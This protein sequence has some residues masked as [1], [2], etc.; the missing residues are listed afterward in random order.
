MV[1]KTNRRTFVKASS[2]VGSSILG[3]SLSDLTK[4]KRPERL[5]GIVYHNQTLEKIG[6]V[7][8]RL[9][10]TNDSVEGSIRLPE[11]QFNVD[12]MSPL[13]VDQTRE[14]RH[15]KQKWP[16]AHDKFSTSLTLLDTDREGVTGHIC[17][18]TEERRIGFVLATEEQ[19]GRE[20]AR[21][22][23]EDVQNELGVKD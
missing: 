16:S 23:V 14:V 20:A 18:P 11:Q 19:G 4:G 13:P 10:R 21:V 9:V 8:A 5:S 22:A 7:D 3:I 15:F 1:P 17:D 6:N 2:T 12:T